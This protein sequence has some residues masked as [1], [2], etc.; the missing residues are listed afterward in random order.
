[1]PPGRPVHPTTKSFDDAKLMAMTEPLTVRIDRLKGNVTSP[2]PLPDNADGTPGSTGWTK[3]AVQRIDGWIVTEL[4]GGGGG[5]FEIS[6]TDSTQ[7]T[8]LVMKWRSFFDPALHPTRPLDLP[9]VTNGYV[10]NI[11]SPNQIP[12]P[13]VQPAN[14]VRFMPPQ[15]P[16]NNQFNW[17]AGVY[18]LPNP[19]P[20]GSPA[21]PAWQSAV[22]Q[23]EEKAEIRRLREENERRDRE[24]MEAKHR[25]ELE[26]EKAANNERFSRLESMMTNLASSLKEA[27][28]PKGP[29]PEIEALKIQLEQSRETARVNE[30]RADQERRDREAERRDRE[31]RETIQRAQEQTNQ[32]IAEMRRQYE[33]FIQQ[34]TAN[35]N[36]TDPMITFMQEQTR[37]FSD[38]VKEITHSNQLAIER[39]QNSAMKPQEVIAMARESQRDIETVTT[40]MT[41]LFGNVVEMQQKVMDNALNMQ[42]QGNSVVEAVSKGL[43]NLKEIGERYVGAKQ[44]EHKMAAQAQIAIAQAQAAAIEAQARA[45]NPAAFANQP[46]VTP[47]PISQDQLAGAPVET[48]VEETKPPRVER[49]W[50]RTDEEWFGTVI[51]SEVLALR[52]GVVQFHESLRSDPVRVDKGGEPLGVSPEDAANGILQAVQVTEQHGVKVPAID[53]LYSKDLFAEF[54]S[55]LLPGDVASDNYRNDVVT[56][57][58][59]VDDDDDEDDEIE[60]VKPNGIAQAAKPAQQQKQKARARA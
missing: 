51:L 37:Q 43:D 55:V 23:R 25:A 42:P 60:P 44:T 7:P 14:Q 16:F 20:V 21:F 28:A 26:R 40:R 36:R 45:A 46:I 10:P 38:M 48:V 24:A 5:M 18:P 32:Q 22:E 4:P 29:N 19:P 57:L 49:L 52:E 6:V 1:M 17:Q 12:L 47:P 54:V 2:I 11:Q 41:N 35:S 8:P 30:A 34:F 56:L 3:E 53:E 58:K 13:P 39:L 9:D 59:S 27:S 15:S 33:G 31:T 50:G